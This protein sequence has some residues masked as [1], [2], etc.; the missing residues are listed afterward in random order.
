MASEK[1]VFIGGGSPFTPSLLYTVVENGAA[2][3]GSEI[4]LLD[5]DDS[6]LPTMTAIG[7]QFAERHGVDLSFHATTDAEE[8]LA[9]AT[10]V[11]FGY[12]V[13]GSEHMAY[14]ITIPTEH[15]ISGDETTGPGGTFMAQCSIPVTV[16]YCR[17]M[18]DLCPDAW[19]ISYVNPANAVADAV[20]RE[21][22][23]S[24]ISVCDCHPGFVMGTL[25]RLLDQPPYERRY[26]RSE[27]I[28]ARAI[29]VNH[30]NW[31][32]EITL[33]G[34]DA[35]PLLEEGI[36]RAMDETT[37]DRPLEFMQE[38]IDTYGYV[39]PC[40]FHAKPLLRQQR[41]LEERRR[42]DVRE[43]GTVIGWSEERWEFAQ[44]LRDGAAYEDHPDNY[45]FHLFHARQAIGIMVSIVEDEGREWGG[46]NFRNGGAISN[47][48][49]DAI[50]EGP[51][52][53]DGNGISP[54]AMGELPKP[55]L[56]ITQQT[57]NWADLAVDAAL[58]GDE[59]RLYQSLLACPYVNDM[60]PAREIMDDLLEAHAEYLPQY[61]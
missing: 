28:K 14:D 2:L 51:C 60:D 55:V 38:L 27:D 30:L 48:P 29:G 7:A 23:V 56:G 22:D 36:E 47:L 13:G 12:R 49:D 5:I 20:R 26:A 37:F 43:E 45:A 46:I 11:F 59:D 24:F 42:T 50:V 35:Y 61:Q 53:V 54:I 41:F 44:E 34:E 4:W 40:P 39:H 52:I 17:L 1:I 57:I 33:D 3:D 18:E 9:D 19:A 16:E 10:F 25:P 32:V 8:A 15:G 31:F 58:T 6:R 21:T